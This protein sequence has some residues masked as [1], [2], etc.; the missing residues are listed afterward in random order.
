MS[1]LAE[2]LLG[3]AK[4]NQTKDVRIQKW[5]E[6]F[7][8]FFWSQFCDRSKDFSG[9]PTMTYRPGSMAKFY[10]KLSTKEF[11]DKVVNI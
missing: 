3:K 10:K 4:E 8:S 2:I 7:G 9:S 6:F 11:C 5:D 1:F